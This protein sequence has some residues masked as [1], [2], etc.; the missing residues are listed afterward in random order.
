MAFSSKVI[1]LGLVKTQCLPM[2]PTDIIVLYHETAHYCIHEST[3]ERLVEQKGRG[4]KMANSTY[5]KNPS[6]IEMPL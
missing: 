4:V 1:H 5:N 2:R 3:W 6:M